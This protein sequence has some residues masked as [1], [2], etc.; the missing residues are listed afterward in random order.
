M[1][2]LRFAFENFPN[3]FMH[4]DPD[5]SPTNDSNISVVVRVRGLLDGEYEACSES[6]LSCTDS[7]TAVIRD[8]IMNE[9]QLLDDRRSSRRASDTEKIFTFDHVF[10]SDSSQQ[11]IFAAVGSSLVDHVLAGVN[12]TIFAY[13]A[14]SAGKTYTM[15]G[16]DSDPGLMMLT[17]DALFSRLSSNGSVQVR[18]SFVEIYNEIVRDLL[19]VSDFSEGGL[20]IRDDRLTNQTYVQGACE[21]CGIKDVEDMVELL[22]LGNTRRT[23]EPTAANETSS[24]SHAILQIF[25]ER[26]DP[27]TSEIIH[28]KLSLIDLAGSERA[29]NTQNRGLRMTEGGSINKSLLALGNCIKALTADNPSGFVPYRDSKLTRL[30]RDSIGGNCRTV[31]IANVSPY[32]GHYTDS[33]NTLKFAIGAKNVRVK[34]RRNSFFRNPQDEIRNYKRMISDLQCTVDS[35]QD[36]LR[37]SS[38]LPTPTTHSSSAE[39]F[40]VFTDD[41]EPS[42]PNNR[43][44][45]VTQCLNITKQILRENL[46]ISPIEQG[47]SLTRQPSLVRNKSLLSLRHSGAPRPPNTIS[48]L[49]SLRD[50]LLLISRSIPVSTKTTL[51]VIASATITSS[52][53]QPKSFSVRQPLRV[54]LLPNTFSREPGSSQKRSN[55]SSRSSSGISFN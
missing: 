2:K 8:V 42:E 13:G 3:P 1:T 22:Q 32:V 41:E 9:E 43:P 34:L 31:M 26:T 21:V 14:T 20:E 15:L 38:P 4:S 30:L 39:E 54:S 19:S 52:D 49:E 11:D 27:D 35:L 7:R 36:Q 5:Y 12:S 40:H 25:L 16:T 53:W 46:S 48:T 47:G 44:E 6:T 28:S 50:N 18:C 45:L 51:P 24:R 23:T 10:D 29:R 37:S 55:S 17:I 33:L